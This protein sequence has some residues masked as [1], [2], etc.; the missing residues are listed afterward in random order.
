LRDPRHLNV[1]FEFVE[2][3]ALQ[4]LLD[5]R[6]VVATAYAGCLA[7]SL[8]LSPVL[9]AM[10]LDDALSMGA[11]LF[12][13]GPEQGVEEMR[14]AARRVVGAVE[15]LRSMSVGW[16]AYQAGRIDSQIRGD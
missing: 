15:K 1:S 9:K 6:G 16:Q 2:A 3:E 5:L 14:E 4:L 10:G 12:S 11:L 8:K 7:P 13:P